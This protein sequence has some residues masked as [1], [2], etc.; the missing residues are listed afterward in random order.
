[1]FWA[2]ID[3]L[4]TTE[5]ALALFGLGALAFAAKLV[6]GKLQ[7]P[8]LELEPIREHT[9]FVDREDRRKLAFVIS[10]RLTNK[11]GRLITIKS[12]KM[13]GYSPKENPDPI[14][15]RGE[16]GEVSLSFP[17]YEHLYAGKEVKVKPYS[18]LNVWMYYESGVVKL[19]NLIHAPIVLKDERGRRRSIQVPVPRHIE[20]I[21]I[22]YSA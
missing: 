22:L 5:G 4:K 12:C 14:V 19:S 20:Q 3:F 6:H 1:M 18:S 16:G 7:I 11:T 15:L 17:P 10:L 13:S 2:L 9:W 21:K 8:G